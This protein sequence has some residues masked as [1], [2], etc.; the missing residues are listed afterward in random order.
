MQIVCNQSHE[1]QI[2]HGEIVEDHLYFGY[3][4]YNW[5]VRQTTWQVLNSK[6]SNETSTKNCWN[7]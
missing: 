7:Y 6:F 4:A 5:S 1:K 3:I 2:L